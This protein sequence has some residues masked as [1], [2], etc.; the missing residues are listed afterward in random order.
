MRKIF[1]DRFN[2]NLSK[3]SM[4]ILF[5]PIV[6]LIGILAY[7]L[8]FKLMK[9]KEHKFTYSGDSLP[10]PYLCVYI[11]S[12]YIDIVDISG[13]LCKKR[14]CGFGKRHDGFCNILRSRYRIVCIWSCNKPFR[15]CHD[16]CFV[17][18][19]MCDINCIYKNFN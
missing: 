1:V 17:D 8:I 3:S 18:N 19:N 10:E 7:P 2:I 6:G 12:Q 4:F 13:E 9:Y 16:V 11:N 15:L 5:I 14:K